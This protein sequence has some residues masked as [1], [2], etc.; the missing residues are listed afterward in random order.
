MKQFLVELVGR[1]HIFT[2]KN[3]TSRE[4]LPYERVEIKDNALSESILN[5]IEMGIYSLV[6]CEE[7]VEKDELVEKSF[8]P[9]KRKKEEG[10]N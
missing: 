6:Q 8:V 7:Q 3:G 1:S 5:G 9:K 4:I 10:G 2:L